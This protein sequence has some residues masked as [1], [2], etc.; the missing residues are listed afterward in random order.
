MRGFRR[1]AWQS[2]PSPMESESPSP[3][4]PMQTS[5]RLAACAPLAI[6]GIRPCTPLKPCDW[7]RKYAVVF[8]EQPIPLSLATPYGGRSSSQHASTSAAV[9]ES[10]PH[11]A[12]RVD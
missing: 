5:L 9:T 4:I 7:R 1:N 12:Q 10:C 3:E 11:P 6:D 8:D 2:C